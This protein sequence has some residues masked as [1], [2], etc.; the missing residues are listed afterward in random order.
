KTAM[1]KLLLIVAIVVSAVARAM[2]VKPGLGPRG[3]VIAV[4][5]NPPT[6]KALHGNIS[7]SNAAQVHVYPVDCLDLESTLKLYSAPRGDAGATRRAVDA[8]SVSSCRD[9]GAD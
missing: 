5:S 1:R 3:R 6:L 9:R 7:A 4:E 8:R 2:I